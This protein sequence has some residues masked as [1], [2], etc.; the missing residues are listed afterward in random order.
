MDYKLPNT[1]ETI[2]SS[3]KESFLSKEDQQDLLW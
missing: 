1:D 2:H 3:L